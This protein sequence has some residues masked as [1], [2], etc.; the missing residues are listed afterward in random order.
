MTVQANK[1]LACRQTTVV[2]LYYKCKTRHLEAAVR[3]RAAGKMA[4]HPHH[5]LLAI[6]A[7]LLACHA[8]NFTLDIACNIT[9]IVCRA[10]GK[11]RP[12]QR[13]L[14]TTL[15]KRVK[16]LFEM[17]WTEVNEERPFQLIRGRAEAENVDVDEFLS[18]AE[19]YKNMP[20]DQLDEMVHQSGAQL[21]EGQAG[22]DSDDDPTTD[23]EEADELEDDRRSS[24]PEHSTEEPNIQIAIAAAALSSPEVSAAPVNAGTNTL[25]VTSDQSSG[26]LPSSIFIPPNVASNS[27]SLSWPR[28]LDTNAESSPVPNIQAMYPSGF[29]RGETPS[30]GPIYGLDGVPS[31][32]LQAP[33]LQSEKNTPSDVH[34]SFSVNTNSNCIVQKGPKRLKRTLSPASISPVEIS[35]PMVTLMDIGLE[36]HQSIQ[37]LREK[38]MF[39][40]LVKPWQADMKRM[41]EAD[42]ELLL[43][44]LPG[45]GMDGH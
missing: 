13:L 22:E 23:S 11:V 40:T 21:P 12:D 28:I 33:A 41:V 16:V 44:K 2:Y 30:F 1:S 39:E 42:D 8:I 20:N 29:G 25:Q 34:S 45:M 38:A 18:R 9:T 19:P 31:A 17:T 14:S 35:V 15:R 6:C 26:H 24:S 27:T 37:S 32:S 43:P 10:M 5:D 7:S 4:N 36:Y 3:R